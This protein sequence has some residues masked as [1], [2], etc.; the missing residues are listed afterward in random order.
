MN[1]EGA[2][3]EVKDGIDKSI[4]GIR[5]IAARTKKLDEARIRVVDVVQN[6]TAIAQ[7]NAASTEE[8]SASA[9]EVGSIISSIA[10]NAK[11]LNEIANEMEENINLF[12]VE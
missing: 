4:D 9:A 11:Q 5:A 1:T 8:T 12:V 10:E 2:F 6:L 3:H 7:E